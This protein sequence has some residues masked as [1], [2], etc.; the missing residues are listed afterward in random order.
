MS[1]TKDKVKRLKEEL[2]GLLEL[3]QGERLHIL[4]A[5]VLD[6]ATEDST[7]ASTVSSLARAYIES[8]KGQR[9]EGL[10]FGEQVSPDDLRDDLKDDLK[11]DHNPEDDPHEDDPKD[12]NG[13]T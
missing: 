4:Q 11:G 5:V 8:L 13:T 3:D 1:R 6:R 7:D 12:D 2:Q 9:E 10:R